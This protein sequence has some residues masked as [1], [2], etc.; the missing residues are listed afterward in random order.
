[1]P[2]TPDDQEYSTTS[3]PKARTYVSP[4]GAPATPPASQIIRSTIPGSG[5]GADNVLT[6][7]TTTPKEKVASYLPYLAGAALLFLFLRRRK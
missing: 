2:V 7:K 4:S 3:R 6:P 5:S 1:M